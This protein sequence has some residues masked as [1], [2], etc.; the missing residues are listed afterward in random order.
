MHVYHVDIFIIY[1]SL[2][3][4]CLNIFLNSIHFDLLKW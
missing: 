4:F 1:W 2:Y 3:C